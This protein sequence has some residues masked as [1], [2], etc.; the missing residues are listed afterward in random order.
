MKIEYLGHAGFIVTIGDTAI[1]IDPWFHGAFFGSWFPYPDNRHLQQQVLDRHFDYLY[2]SHTHDDHFDTELLRKFRRNITVICPDY[3]SKSVARKLARFGYKDLIELGHRETHVFRDG[4]D[5]RWLVTLYLDLSHKE[6]SG[7]LIDDGTYRFLDLNDCNTVLSE[8]PTRVELLA[9]QY[10]GAMWYPN[11]YDYPPDLAQAKTEAV[12]DD[13]QRMLFNKI[14]VIEPGSYLPSAGPACFLDPELWKF[15][16][17]TKTIFPTWPQVAPRFADEFPDLPIALLQPGDSMVD[18]RVEADSVLSTTDIASYSEQRR[19]EWDLHE[20]IDIPTSDVESYFDRLRL[21]NPHALTD[22]KVFRLASGGR[23]WTITLGIDAV[24]VRE[25]SHTD[26]GYSFRV[27]PF[28]LRAILDERDGWEEALL[29]MRVGLRRDPDVYDSTLLGLLR[30]G[31]EPIQ[32][33]QMMNEGARSETVT[34]AGFRFQRYCPHAGEDLS[35]A[36]ITDGLII[37][38]RHHWTWDL[39]TGECV[40]GGSLKL[41]VTSEC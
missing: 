9:A 7:I 38:P 23:Q 11:C 22:T 16:D 8:L 2:L 12:R 36:E 10:S 6:D 5:A 13:L 39:S 30:Y 34:R 28:V 17:R 29:S 20:A 41:A 3:R 1:L 25:G 40:K 19:D 27:P 21:N 18:G 37:C 15:N 24:S 31:A 4:P 26:I 35:Y 33:R 14:R 32:T